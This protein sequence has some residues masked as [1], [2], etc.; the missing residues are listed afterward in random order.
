M[1]TETNL[2]FEVE[3]GD[4]TKFDDDGRAKR[5]GNVKTATAHIITA[6]IGSG[7]LSLAW[8]LAQLGWIAGMV[9]L[10]IF[11]LITMFTSS[12]LAN[13]YRS[14]DPINGR[15][16]YTYKEAVKNNL[17]GIKYKFCGVAQYSNLVGITI[18]YT[19]TSAISMAAIRRSHCFHHHGHDA[20]CHVS[21]NPY[22]IIFGVMQMILSQIPNFHDLAGLSYIAAIMSFT[23]AFIGIGLSV[24][25]I[26]EGKGGKTSVTGVT[27]GV[28][29]TTSQ[30]V[31]NSLQAIGNIA[32]AYSYSNVLIE[33]QDTLKSSPPENGEMKKATTV[34]VS[35]TSVFY[36][37]CGSL[38]YAAF[39]K[40]APGN[41][42]TGFGFFEPYWLVDI[43]NICIVVHLVGAYQVFC[44]PTYQLVE[45]W[46]RHRYPEND[47]IVKERPILIPF[48]GI[49]NVNVFRM[50]WR[51]SYVI[52]TSVIAMIFPVFNSVLGLIG[53]ASFWP[54]TV[55]FP[56][57]MHISQAKIRS[58]SLPWIWL[59][60]LSGACLVIT[61]V[62]AA[63]CVQ[64]IIVELSHYQ[65]FKSVS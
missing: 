45:D 8:A 22:M 9:A 7:V 46:L 58:F 38:G 18:G 23:Y 42:L 62:A 65:P 49:Y 13:S 51:T 32:F 52:F 47:F 24:A 20:G 30:K 59:K 37:L 60:I 29:V 27:A 19:I 6:V 41:F 40:D 57:E 64:G 3:S 12:L 44:Q 31:W 61:L 50:I 36:L 14:P 43:A 4:T 10:L 39:G 35:I 17:G 48:I 2:S 28:D 16:N 34:A 55:Y 21:N 1:K 54:L 15:R 53:A 63:A 26:A 56:V 25:Q 11:S 33:I 5:T